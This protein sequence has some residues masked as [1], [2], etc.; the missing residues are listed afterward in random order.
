ML[1]VLLHTLQQYERSP[2][3]KRL[4]LIR[5]LFDLNVLLHTSQQYGRSTLCKS[6]CLIRTLFVLNVLL[7]TLQQYGRSPCEH[8]CL[9]RSPSHLNALLHTL[10][11]YRCSLVCAWSCSFRVPCQKHKGYTLG[12]FLKERTSILHAMCELTKK[13]LVLKSCILKQSIE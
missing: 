9:I 2:L 10:H 6:L 1:N 8:L 11:E 7:H 3:C 4:C 5:S 13:L 12:Y